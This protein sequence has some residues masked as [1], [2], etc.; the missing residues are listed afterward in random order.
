MNDHKEHC[1][2]GNDGTSEPHGCPYQEDVNNDP[3]PEYC[4]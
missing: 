1:R 2:Y 3:N 4:Y